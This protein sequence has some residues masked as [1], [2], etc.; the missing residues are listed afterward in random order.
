MKDTITQQKFLKELEK[1]VQGM[2]A[3]KIDLVIEYVKMLKKKREV[4]EYA[5]MLKQKREEESANE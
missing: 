5:K 2:P 3:A 1:Q 4:I